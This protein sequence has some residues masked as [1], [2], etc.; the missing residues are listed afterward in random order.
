MK[1]D[2]NR[3][4]LSPFIFHF[5]CIKW[6]IHDLL[7]SIKNA[8]KW[9]GWIYIQNTPIYRM[10]LSFMF[11]IE[12]EP[13][14]CQVKNSDQHWSCRVKIFSMNVFKIR[15]HWSASL[16]FRI[17]FYYNDLHSHHE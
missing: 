10:I 5:G 3:L 8:N 1:I 17:F 14:S 15:A 7:D 6:C 9:H 16:T 13:K 4:N 11:Y 12:I 2:K